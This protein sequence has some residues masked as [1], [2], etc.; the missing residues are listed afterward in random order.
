MAATPPARASVP[1]ARRLTPEMLEAGRLEAGDPRSDAGIGG[2]ADICAVVVDPTLPSAAAAPCDAC[3]IGEELGEA[4]CDACPIGEELGEA[5][6]DAC[7]IGEEL[8]VATEEA[9]EPA[10]NGISGDCVWALKT[11]LRL[12]LG[13][14]SNADALRYT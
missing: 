2:M 9:A 12:V 10:P 7:P 4:P 8:G 1:I 6:C 11:M 5:P 14:M 13:G 3:P